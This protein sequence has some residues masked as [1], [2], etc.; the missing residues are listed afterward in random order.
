M[1]WHGMAWHD[2]SYRVLC[3]LFLNSE[4]VILAMPYEHASN[5]SSLLTPP[6]SFSIVAPIWLP[7]TELVLQRFGSAF[8]RRLTEPWGG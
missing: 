5:D 8:K 2:H 1:A 6:D 7:C 3:S 4:S